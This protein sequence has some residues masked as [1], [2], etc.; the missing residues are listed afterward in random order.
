[1]SKEALVKFF[2]DVAEA[3]PIPVMCVFSVFLLACRVCELFGTA[4]ELTLSPSIFLS[5]RIYSR[6]SVSNRLGRRRARPLTRRVCPF[7]SLF[8]SRS[9]YPGASGGIDLSSVD[10]N[11]MADGSANICGV[12]LT[13]GGVGK[14]TRITGHTASKS[15]LAS[16]PAGKE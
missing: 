14:L 5:R 12:K 16:R 2:V 10:I 8:V 15:F 1:M 4:S 13:C 7:A 9:D 11:A 3:S 6:Y